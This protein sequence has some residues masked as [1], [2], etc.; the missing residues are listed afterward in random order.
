MVLE[1][2]T[3]NIIHKTSTVKYL[4][5]GLLRVYIH[6]FDRTNMKGS[7]LQD[8]KSWLKVK[9]LYVLYSKCHIKCQGWSKNPMLMYRNANLNAVSLKAN[10]CTVLNHAKTL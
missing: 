2:N 10:N 3:T 5:S 6:S 9:R 7:L 1:H 8:H 4:Y